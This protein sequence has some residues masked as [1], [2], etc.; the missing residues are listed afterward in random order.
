MNE[1]KKNDS[2]YCSVNNNTMGPVIIIPKLVPLFIQVFAWSS[3]STIDVVEECSISQKVI[4]DNK[5]DLALFDTTGWKTTELNHTNPIPKDRI[6]IVIKK[7]A[8][9]KKQNEKYMRLKLIISKT[10]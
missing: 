5:T 2:L 8:Y 9:E 1:K 7:S 4:K 3:F 10:F 6:L